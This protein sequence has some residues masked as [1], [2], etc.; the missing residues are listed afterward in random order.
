MHLYEGAVIATGIHRFYLIH[1]T[2][3][4]RPEHKC[5]S[6]N[7]TLLGGNDRSAVI[8]WFTCISHLYGDDEY[9]FK[10]IL[11]I[12]VSQPATVHILANDVQVVTAPPHFLWAVKVTQTPS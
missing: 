3:V 5:I 10:T 12:R 9:A 8:K 7:K 4:F 6:P 11:I 1:P 2:L